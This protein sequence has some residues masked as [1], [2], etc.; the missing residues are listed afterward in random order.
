[1]LKEMDNESENSKGQEALIRRE[2]SGLL[3]RVD[4][5]LRPGK[6]KKHETFRSR[7]ALKPHISQRRLGQGRNSSGSCL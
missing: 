2:K 3:T 6:E 5:V 1:M 4:C 7:K